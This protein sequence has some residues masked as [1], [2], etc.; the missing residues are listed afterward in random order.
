MSEEIRTE[1]ELYER[2]KPALRTKMEEMRRNGFTYIKEDDI[3]NY[4]KE[5]KWTREK[6]LSLYQMV[7]DI[8]NSESSLID[9]YLKSKLNLRVRKR[10]FEERE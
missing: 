1:E 10:Y 9:D 3:W 5:K 4:L 7:D 8:L 6:G 2:V